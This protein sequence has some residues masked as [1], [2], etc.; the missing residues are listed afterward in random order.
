[1][2][3]K[4]SSTDIEF[5]KPIYQWKIQNNLDYFIENIKLNY[6]FYLNKEFLLDLDKFENLE[7]N[8]NFDIIEK[9][10]YN[11]YEFHYDKFKELEKSYI[12]FSLKTHNH[13]NNAKIDNDNEIN[14]KI[15]YDDYKK[16]TESKYEYPILHSTTYL[17]D[18]IHPLFITNID[19][20][21][22]KFKEFK[23]ETS[24]VFCFPKK[25]QHIV[26]DPSKYHCYLEIPDKKLQEYGND[27][28]YLEVSL[29][30]RKN[31]PQDIPLY[32][33]INSNNSN[34]YQLDYQVDL[35]LDFEDIL[36]NNVKTIIDFF[37][38][39][40]EDRKKKDYDKILDKKESFLLNPTFFEGIFYSKSM[41]LL[42]PFLE[43]MNEPKYDN[44]NDKKAK[45]IFMFEKEKKTLDNNFKNKPIDIITDMNNILNTKNDILMYNRFLQRH[46]FKKNF[47]LD[48][49]SWLIKECETYAKTN[50]GWI[51]DDYDYTYLHSEKIQSI[52]GFILNS[53][54]TIIPKIIQSYC[55]NHI[56]PILNILKIIIIK[57]D[58]N[59][60]LEYKE[61]LLKDEGFFKFC[62]PLNQ[63]GIDFEGGGIYF[64]DGITSYL[65]QGDILI[66][67]GK[68]KHT[69]IPITKGIKY[70]LVGFIDL[71][72]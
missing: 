6:E 13:N 59:N 25:G 5:N 46:I 16:K 69:N 15:K 65:E 26:F 14:L 9:V 70:T 17:T 39:Y 35:K 2:Y 23:D 58:V 56:K 42:K 68:I 10:V 31:C 11:I 30:E 72:L 44:E 19:N 52:F 71:S 37:Q 66:Y 32:I 61:N 41:T 27:S 3:N 28:L 60:K 8:V 47:T 1:M 50:G 43:K 53:T 63:Q 20:N 45:D 54:E 29:W 55:I 40:S 64:E 57:E 51:N 62:I 34:N 48:I 12:T 24:I 36:H 33:S 22:Y 7:D 49:C 21:Q 38:D 67:S 18:S 4:M